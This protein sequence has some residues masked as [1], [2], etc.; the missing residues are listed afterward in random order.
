MYNAEQKGKFIRDRYTTTANI[1]HCERYFNALEPYE[2]GWRADICTRTAEELKPAIEH[3]CGV[4]YRSHLFQIKMLRQYTEWCIS[5]NIP[6]AIDGIS[7]IDN[8][9]IDKLVQSTMSGPV[10]LQLYLNRFCS[11]EI[12]DTVDNTIR[13]FHWAAFA[14]VK[15]QD[16]ISLTKKNVDL[17]NMVFKIDGK[18]FPIYREGVPAIRKCIEL[19][20]FHF[21][22]P[23]FTDPVYVDRVEGE[24]LFRGFR[25]ERTFKSMSAFI[26]LKIK[27]V[28]DMLDE[29]DEQITSISYDNL[30]LSGVF[31]RLF[32]F[33]AAGIEPDFQALARELY[34]GKAKANLHG[35][36]LKWKYNRIAKQYE[37]DYARWKIPIWK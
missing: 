15:R 21:D 35:N 22:H 26:S 6:G 18:E 28:N 20:E 1:Q 17:F 14:G 4:R 19:K 24:S 34:D 12:N 33:E 5:H 25:G 9:F 36:D 2:E 31:Y 11:P 23:S 30:R 32:E 13:C 8:L 7:G 27:S 3:I 16:V 29:Q 37:E 10:Q